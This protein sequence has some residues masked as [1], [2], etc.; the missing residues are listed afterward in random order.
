MKYP[1]KK[2]FNFSSLLA[3][4]A[5]FV[6]QG[7]LAH[8]YILDPPVRSKMCN[9]GSSSEGCNAIRSY[10]ENE[11][12]Y[13]PNGILYMGEDYE[14]Y[15]NSLP[16]GKICGANGQYNSLNLPAS[17]WAKTA[18]KPDSAG[19]ISLTYLFTA[20]H[21]TDF[22]TYYITKNGTDL[23][24]PLAWSDMEEIKTFTNVTNPP[25]GKWTEKVRLPSGQRGPHVIALMWP[26]SKARHGTNENFI[27]CSDVD[28]QGESVE[29]W[30]TV[31]T[32]IRA[33]E[34]LK[35][36]ATVKFRLF[37]NARAGTVAGEVSMS[38]SRD[39]SAAEWLYEIAAAFNAK[40]FA[41]Q[42]GSLQGGNV[43]LSSGKTNYQVYAKKI[44]FSY[45]L[46]V[47]ANNVVEVPGEVPAQ[48]VVGKD[49]F[50]VA[51]TS[52]GFAYKL[53][54][55]KSLHA[56]TYQWNKLSGP[57][58]LRNAD[59]AV[60]EAVVG[61]NQ[62]GVSTYELTVTN[63]DGQQHRSTMKVTAT[64]VGV[65][66]SGAASIVEGQVSSLKAQANF[67]G[68]GGSAP[69]Y[70]WK[71]RNPNGAEI[72]QGSQQQLPL[73][74]LMPG[75][76]QATVD[77]SSPHGG[78]SATA[79]QNIVVEKKGVIQPP[80]EVVGACAGVPEWTKKSYKGGTEVQKN[81]RSYTSKWFVEPHHVPGSAGWTGDPWKDNGACK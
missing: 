7:A 62:T 57:F 15:K 37:D 11:A 4:S 68:S 6:V 35:K 16:D 54:G 23:T 29:S 19:E 50:V 17:K 70:S 33:T 38:L 51:T 49:I 73:S 8:G 46:D 63:K 21:T 76:Y 14:D 20:H 71:V 61:K 36:G 48:A 1:A 3:C 75:N 47:K 78:R 31:G 32:G 64:A 69:T 22:M 2:R 44:G 34:D 13:T 28:I 74:T 39:M 43:T 27:S 12:M 45:A 58:S 56:A 40:N 24:K 25:G 52:S 9:T 60:A 77:V 42:I 80:V 79:Q 81:G 53:D 26:V 72:L 66:I 18:I 65:K 67:S 30:N 59:N 55:S 41:A 5:L 10:G